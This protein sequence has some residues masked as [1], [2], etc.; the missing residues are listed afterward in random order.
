MSL[1]CPGSVLYLLEIYVYVDS[2]LVLELPP[3]L[4]NH[5]PFGLNILLILFRGSTSAVVPVPSF[6]ATGRAALP[7]MQVGLLC[8]LEVLFLVHGLSFS[9]SLGKIKTKL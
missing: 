8:G 3:T 2:F 9:L 6:G 4:N 7:E 1:N 5:L